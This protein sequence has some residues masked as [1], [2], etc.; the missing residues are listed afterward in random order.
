MLECR[1]RSGGAH[2]YQIQRAPEEIF[3]SK[4]VNFRWLSS[5]CGFQKLTVTTNR[6]ELKDGKTSWTKANTVMTV[7]PNALAAVFTLMK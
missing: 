5:R 1:D 7:A 6:L 4:D 3:Q 2:A